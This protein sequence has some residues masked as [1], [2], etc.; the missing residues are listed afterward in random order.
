MKM[1]TKTDKKMQSALA[2]TGHI[3][4]MWMPLKIAYNSIPGISIGIAYKGKIIYAKGFGFADLDKKNKADNK[5][6]YHVASNSKMFTATAIMQLVEEKKIRLDDKVAFYLPWF[7]AKNKDKDASTITIRQLLSH[8]AGIFRDGDTDHWETGKFPKDLEKS[9]SSK[10]LIIENLTG[11]KYTNYGYSLLGLIIEKASGVSYENYVSKHIFNPLGLKY[12]HTDYVKGINHIAT[13]YGY[14]MPYEKRRVF[15]HYSANV[16]TPATGFVSN[17]PDILKF[18]SSFS[19]EHNGKS[20][21]SRESKKEM[22]RGYEK[23]EDGDE[24]GLGMDITFIDGAKIVGHG[25]GFSGF[26]TRTLFDMDTNIAVVVLTNSISVPASPI[27]FGILD[28]IRRL[29]KNSGDY[30][31]NFNVSYRKYEGT[32]RNSWG[33]GTICRAGDIMIDFSS[34][35]NYPIKNGAKLIPTRKQ[36]LF[37]YKSKGVFGPYGEP[38]EFKNFKNGKANKYIVGASS[39]VRFNKPKHRKV[40]IS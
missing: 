3:I 25:G 10:S 29:Y 15:G 17:V 24:Y 11:F 37:I 14:K 9:F 4:D 20:I 33:D 32:Y 40:A 8:T 26:S 35:T 39:S 16:Y 21:L 34:D 27:A 30:E 38:A 18:I 1:L 36:N 2:Q 22:T 5:T 19:L 6:L 12:T 28:S 23:T 31:T 13:G 7:K